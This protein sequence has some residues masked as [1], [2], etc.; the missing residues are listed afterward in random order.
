MTIFKNNK[1][2]PQNFYLNCDD[3]L[4]VDIQARAICNEAAQ[5]SPESFNG[6]KPCFKFILRYCPPYEH[7]KFFDLR[8]LQEAARSNTRFKDEYR[9]YILIDIAEWKFHF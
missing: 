8:R 1:F 3:K 9:G 7:E 2:F 5:L 4:E 6:E